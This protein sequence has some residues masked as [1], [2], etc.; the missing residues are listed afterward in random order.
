MSPMDRRGFLPRL[1]ALLFAPK[2]LD[3]LE[4]PPV[5]SAAPLWSPAAVHP[6]REVLA[7]RDA[8]AAR[9]VPMVVHRLVTPGEAGFVLERDARGR[10]TRVYAVEGEQ[11]AEVRNL[12][13]VTER[14]RAF[15][16]EV[17]DEDAPL[18]IAG[19]TSLEVR[20]F[21][22]GDEA[23]LL[24]RR[25]CDRE[26]FVEAAFQR[27]SLTAPLLAR[28]EPGGFEPWLRRHRTAE[29]RRQR[30]MRAPLATPRGRLP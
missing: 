29:R 2:A 8:L 13:S 14:R 9:A 25:W 5:P 23:W 1:L 27:F 7:A 28:V 3:A 6:A 4:A 26:M 22:S 10:P 15:E 11:Y 30:G 19:V 21:V 18:H 12:F 16:V 17:F 24:S 20:A